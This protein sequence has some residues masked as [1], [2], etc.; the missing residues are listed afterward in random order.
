[1]K[2]P[3]L[4]P[5]LLLCGVILFLPDVPAVSAPNTDAPTPAVSQW[6]QAVPPVKGDPYGG[7]VILTTVPFTNLV[8]DGVSYPT[9]VVSAR[10]GTTDVTFL[11]DTGTINTAITPSLAKRLGL[12]PKSLLPPGQSVNEFGRPVDGVT[13]SNLVLGDM[14]FTPA[15][16]EVYPQSTWDRLG[17][18]Q[19][20]I[21]GRDSLE[22]CMVEFDFPHHRLTFLNQAAVTPELRAQAGYGAASYAADITRDQYGFYKTDLVMTNGA[23]HLTEAA[24]VDTGSSSTQ[25]S[26]KAA[27]A[28]R[29]FPTGP[30]VDYHV[31]RKAE[32]V[33]PS[34]VGEMQVG[35]LKLLNAP[36]GYPEKDEPEGMGVGTVLG[37]DI[38]SGYKVLLDFPGRKMYLQPSSSTVPVVTVGP[39]VKP[40]TAKTP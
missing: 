1:M 3:L 5:I 33:V 19:D 36:V 29:L 34:R 39:G 20:G 17:M 18:K 23:S 13:V 15:Q 26:A 7:R 9:P 30:P 21:L 12:T 32:P 11:V 22:F 6:P 25:I 2:H 35:Q 27:E 38:L 24:V 14:N 8:V 16:E 10:I 31:E 4:L 40:P 37:M 28:L